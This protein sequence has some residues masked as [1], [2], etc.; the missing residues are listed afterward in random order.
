[1]LV[2]LGITLLM[3]FAEFRRLFGVS[4]RVSRAS[5]LCM[6]LPVYGFP[7]AVEPTERLARLFSRHGRLIRAGRYVVPT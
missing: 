6:D 5:F 4:A 3:L 7:G 2:A 1:M